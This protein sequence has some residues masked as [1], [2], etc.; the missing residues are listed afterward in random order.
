MTPN[1]LNWREI[2]ITIPERK[3]ELQII[4]YFDPDSVV[5]NQVEESELLPIS[6]GF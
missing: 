1:A 4:S 5:I 6:V 3:L 2:R